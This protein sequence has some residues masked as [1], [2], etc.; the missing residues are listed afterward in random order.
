[1]KIRACMLQVESKFKLP[2]LVG[3]SRLKRFQSSKLTQ[4]AS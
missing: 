3:N 2:D 4:S 1:M